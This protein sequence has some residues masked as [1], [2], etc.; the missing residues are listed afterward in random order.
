MR[1]TDMQA[2]NAFIELAQPLSP[3]HSL[4][5]SINE[6][7]PGL[8][9]I[10]IEVDNIDEAVRDLRAKGVAVSEPE[11]GVREGTRVARIDPA[12]ANGVRIEVVER[13]PPVI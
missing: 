3:E 13:R 4:A 11:F 10:S 12:S 8:Y 5:R 6:R 9:G 2:G 1:L 7:G